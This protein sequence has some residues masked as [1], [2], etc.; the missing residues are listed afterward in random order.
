MCLFGL[1]VSFTLFGVNC[2]FHDKISQGINY[3]PHFSYFIKLCVVQVNGSVLQ[4]LERIPGRIP[5]LSKSSIFRHQLSGVLVALV[6]GFFLV[7]QHEL[8]QIPD[9]ETLAKVAFRLF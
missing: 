4:A 2:F 6:A 7:Q 5:V 9:T 3:S 1:G 8:P